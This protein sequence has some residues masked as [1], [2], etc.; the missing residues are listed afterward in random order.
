MK[1]SD[2][3]PGS[4]CDKVVKNNFDNYYIDMAVTKILAECRNAE[5]TVEQ[6]EIDINTPEIKE[7]LLQHLRQKFNNHELMLNRFLH[8]QPLLPFQ[9]NIGYESPDVVPRFDY[10]KKFIQTSEKIIK[11]INYTC[12]KYSITTAA[13]LIGH[14]SV[15]DFFQSLRDHETASLHPKDKISFAIEHPDMINEFYIPFMYVEDFS[16]EY[17]LQK[18]ANAISSNQVFLIDDRCV[19]SMTTCINPKGGGF[20]EVVTLD[21]NYKKKSLIKI[22]NKDNSCAAR[23]IVCGLSLL[24]D[25][26]KSS[27]YKSI[28]QG[29]TIKK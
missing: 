4:F 9:V 10:R 12:R 29:K 24:N 8:P 23:A 5:C 7:F 20:T 19:F 16:V 2:P 6:F 14:E 22:L 15:L 1:V 11:E 3:K 18:L 17:V 27:D 26:K 25:D 21:D 28:I 13:A